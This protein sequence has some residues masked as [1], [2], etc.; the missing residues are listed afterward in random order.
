MKQFFLHHKKLHTWLLADLCLLA[1]FALLRESRGAMNAFVGHVSNPIRRFVGRLC[2]RVDFSV[3]E[4]LCVV[5]VLTVIAYVIWSVIAVVRAK[6]RRGRRAYA[7]FLGAAC[8]ALT[9]GVVFC[10][11]WGADYYTD[12]FQEQSGIYAQPV[13]AEDLLRVTVYFAQQTALT[14]DTVARDESGIFAVP[15]VDILA[16]S[17]RAYDALEE[18]FPFLAFDDLGVKPIRLSRVMSMLD[19]TG[20]YCPYT[21]EANVNVDSPACMLPATAAHEMAHQRGYASEQECN[22][23]GILASVTS[24]NDAYEYSGWLMGYIYLG[25][26]LYR[27]APDTYW[28]IRDQLPDGVQ[29]DLAYNNAYWDQFRDTAAQKVS[30]KVYDGMLKAYGQEQ[31]IQS[32]GTV[33]D[34]LVAYYKDIV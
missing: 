12:S 26:A 32:Y 8:G 34:M 3:A 31:G 28:A 17:P 18:Q 25:N 20:V 4:M 21:G 5:L 9:L 19:F 14:A 10:W 22:F 29:A 11:F 30:N 13:A 23:L 15:R 6:G 33:V 27:I 7:A 1:A 2:Y 16:D 24:G